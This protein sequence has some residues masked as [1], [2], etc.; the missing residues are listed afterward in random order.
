MRR[1]ARIIINWEWLILL[2]LLPLLLFPTGWRGLILMIIP[3]LWIIR[4]IANGHFVP[5]TPYD[6]AVLLLM[7]TVLIS[8]AAV[9]DIKLSFPKIAGLLLG[10]AYFYGGVQHTR[11]NHEGEYHLLGLIFIAGTGMAM[12]GFLSMLPTASVSYF[13]S[14]SAVLRGPMEMLNGVLGATVNQN[15]MAGV[16][17]WILPLLLA[18]TIGFWRPMWRNRRWS[19][20]LLHM[21]LV[22]MLL[23][24]VLVLLATRSRGGYLVFLVL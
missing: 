6:S 8:L 15:E 5:P 20:R 2:L 10:I 9:F 21:I 22:A 18:S 19:L 24:N 1:L 17:G 23:F 3:L 16:L 11:D 7:A 14:A 13:A 12:V 4:K